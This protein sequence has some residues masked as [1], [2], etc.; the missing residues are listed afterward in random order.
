MKKNRAAAK[1]IPLLL[2]FL[3]NMQGVAIIEE[4]LSNIFDDT[5]VNAFNCLRKMGL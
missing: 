1:F 5:H 4:T 2:R 3:K